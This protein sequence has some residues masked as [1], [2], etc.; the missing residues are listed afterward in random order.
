MVSVAGSAR[1]SVSRPYRVPLDSALEDAHAT[2]SRGRLD[3][4][5]DGYG[6]YDKYAKILQRQRRMLLA[7][8][9]AIGLIG[10]HKRILKQPHFELP[11]QHRRDQFVEL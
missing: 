3:F 2:F 6:A 11:Q 1:K 4:S 9:D 10:I 7:T 8:H 5:L